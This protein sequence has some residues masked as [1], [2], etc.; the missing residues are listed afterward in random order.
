[1]FCLRCAN[2]GQSRSFMVCPH[3]DHGL[4]WLWTVLWET[5]LCATPGSRVSVIQSTQK[6]HCINRHDPALC[7]T[8]RPC[9][10]HLTSLCSLL[11][12][13]RFQTV[14]LTTDPK[15]TAQL[16]LFP[17]LFFVSLYQSLCLFISPLIAVFL[18]EKCSNSIWIKL[19]KIHIH[20]Q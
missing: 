10:A 16:L 1:M 18:S 4:W 13:S 12:F 6:T 15:F 20:T 17:C 9:C 3:S 7:D 19:H 2:N 5:P 14:S 8:V 11:C